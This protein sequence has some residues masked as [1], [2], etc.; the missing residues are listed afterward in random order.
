M[1]CEHCGRTFRQLAILAIL[2]D[3]G[4]KCHPGAIECAESPTGEHELVDEARDLAPP[5]P[6]PVHVLKGSLTR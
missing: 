1:K 6:L 5:P 2:Q 4:A 3:A